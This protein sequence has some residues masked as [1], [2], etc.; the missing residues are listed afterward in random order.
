[1]TEY[2]IALG[3]NLPT[4]EYD[5]T[6]ILNS[7]LEQLSQTHGISVGRVSAFY[8]TPAWPEGSGPD[9]L[10]G[11]AL[12]RSSKPPE[13]ILQEMHGVEKSLGRERHVR[14]GARTCD[15]DLIGAKGLVLPDVETVSDWIARGPDVTRIPDRLLLPHPR[16]HERAFVLVPLYEIVP[17]WVHPILQLSVQQMIAALPEAEVREVTR[18]EAH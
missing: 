7:A 4:G 10:N 2:M 16:L 12:L 14:W 8:R 17:A 3:S 6:S 13:E 1:M 5:L 9:F 18:I 11:A 15:L